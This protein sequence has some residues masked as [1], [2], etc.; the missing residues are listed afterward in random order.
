M[1]EYSQQFHLQLCDGEKQADVQLPLLELHPDGRQHYR[2][3]LREAEGEP[4][5]NTFTS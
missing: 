5:R 2:D 1:K 4:H 3:V